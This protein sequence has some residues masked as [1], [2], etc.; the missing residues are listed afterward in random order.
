MDDW[1][2]LRGRKHRRAPYI[3]PAEDE[4]RLQLLDSGDALQIA[5]RGFA[6]TVL[7]DAVLDCERVAELRDELTRWLEAP[8]RPGK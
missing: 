8:E 1:N 6:D 5:V 4:R 2:A 7:A 3:L